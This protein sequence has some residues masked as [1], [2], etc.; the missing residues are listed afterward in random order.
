MTKRTTVRTVT[1]TRPFT[2]QGLEETLPPGSYV[3]ETD[4]DLIDSLSFPVY[5]R[6]ATWIRLPQRTDGQGVSQVAL[7]DP[8]ELD[9][10]IAPSSDS[11][12]TSGAK[13]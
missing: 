9:D 2:V 4:E 7:I 12:Q 13:P 5:R 11:D 1:M 3:V 10:A 6:T 8:D